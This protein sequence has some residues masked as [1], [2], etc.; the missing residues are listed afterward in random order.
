MKKIAVIGLGKVGSLVAT[1]LHEQFEVTGL[2][3]IS[4]THYPFLT[5]TGNCNDHEFLL[6]ALQN[7]HA[8][9]SCLPYDKNLVIAEVAHLLGLHYFDL[10]ED[11]ATTKAI[12][13]MA[14]NA[15]GVMIPQCG[16]AP[17]FIGIVAADLC[18]RFVWLE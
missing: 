10:T 16:L 14:K 4:Y 15:K 8:V 7:Q 13:L 1:L 9:V 5:L 18:A 12:R 2:D 3:C 11:V 6:V 17:G